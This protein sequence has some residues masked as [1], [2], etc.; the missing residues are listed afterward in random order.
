MR[1]G[2]NMRII[3]GVKIEDVKRLVEEGYK[4]GEIAEKL[5]CTTENIKY[6]RHKHGIKAVTRKDFRDKT[7]TCLSCGK[8]TVIKR[9]D[10][11]KAFCDDC[12]KDLSSF[13]SKFRG[14][15]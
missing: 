9:S 10:I 15:T 1:G 6:H 12:E 13:E 14:D 11:R 3:R 4:D 5:G 8:Q 7:Y 2:V